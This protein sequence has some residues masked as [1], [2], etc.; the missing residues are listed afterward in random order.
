M[1][2]ECNNM[3]GEWIK[4]KCTCIQYVLSLVITNMLQSLF[5]VITRVALQEY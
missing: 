4:I 3:H 2:S 1:K 5:S